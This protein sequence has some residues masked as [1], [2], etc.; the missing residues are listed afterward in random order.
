ME[1]AFSLGELLVI[2]MSDTLIKF[3]LL[4]KVCRTQSGRNLRLENGKGLLPLRARNQ[5][6]C[7]KDAKPPFPFGTALS[8]VAE[9]LVDINQCGVKFSAIYFSPDAFIGRLRRAAT[10]QTKRTD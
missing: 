9:C 10:Q 6:S 8:E 3:S 7:L 2:P 5:N 4:R 1:I